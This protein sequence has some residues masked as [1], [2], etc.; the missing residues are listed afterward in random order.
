MFVS[1]DPDGLE[2]GRLLGV[3]VAV[4]VDVELIGEP[5]EDELRVAEVL[6]VEG[7]PWAFALRPERRFRVH[8]LGSQTFVCFPIC[9][10]TNLKVKL[11]P[12][13]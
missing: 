4:E 5:L 12:H 6:A 7:D 2:R 10:T 1:Q 13:H 9:F 8:L 11:Q 3:E